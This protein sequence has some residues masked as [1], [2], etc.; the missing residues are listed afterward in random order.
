MKHNCGMNEQAH[1]HKHI[2]GKITGVLAASKMQD[3]SCKNR[4]SNKTAIVQTKI[5]T[6]PQDRHP[7]DRPFQD[8][9]TI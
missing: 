3:H 9:S 7:S 4:T 1:T 6:R 2:V 5:K 8:I